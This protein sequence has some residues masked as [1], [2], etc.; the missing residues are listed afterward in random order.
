MSDLKYCVFFQTTTLAIADS[1][2]GRYR[3]TAVITYDAAGLAQNADVKDDWVSYLPA[4]LV[5]TGTTVPG[6]FLRFTI[7]DIVSR[8]DLSSFKAVLDFDL[9]WDEAT[10]Y[11][12]RQLDPDLQSTGVLCEASALK[13]LGYVAGAAP[14]LAFG[15]A[16]PD[17]VTFASRNSDIDKIIDSFGTGS[18]DTTF[19]GSRAVKRSGLPAVNAGGTTVTEWLDRYFFPF[20]PA[21]VSLNGLATYQYGTSN[22]IV[23]TGAVVLNDETTVYE[24]RVYDVTNGAVLLGTVSSNAVSY[25]VPDVVS[26]RSFKVDVDVAGNGTPGTVSS[27][28]RTVNFVYPFLYGMIS[29]SAPTGSELYTSLTKLVET[30]ATK[31]VALTGTSAYIYFAYP[32]SYGQ[33]TAVYDQNGFDTLASFTVYQAVVLA[34]GLNHDNW[35][36]TYY[37]YRSTNLTTVATK[38]FVF[39][40]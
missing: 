7:S 28:T 10:A 34:S 8:F 14:A 25:T 17:G 38:P 32:A 4:R 31:T 37:V 40:F 27:P 12:D 39:T 6:T 3:A 2:T 18:G 21:T 9:V 20:V 5:A 29:A 33:L 1:S 26:T 19:N 13:K 35:S 22:D 24:R 15:A 16:L 30:K 36:T 23:L 11:A